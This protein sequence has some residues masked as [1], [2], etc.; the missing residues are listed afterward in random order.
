[1]TPDLRAR[2]RKFLFLHGRH[3]ERYLST[4]F[5]PNTHLTGEAL[6]LVYL[7]EAFPEWKCAPRWRATGTRVL[8]GALGW[9]V[10]ADGVYFE[11]A[12]YYHRYTADIYTHFYLLTRQRQP[13]VAESVRPKLE[14][15]LE[16]LVWINRPDGT[17]P[18]VGDDDG[19]RLVLLDER[20]PADFRAALSTG[21]ALFSR[22]DFF[23]VAGE[24]A[25]ETFWL[26][27]EE[28]IKT[29]QGTPAAPP[30]ELSRGFADGGYYVMRDG[31]APASNW[32]LADCGVHGAMNCGHAHA[33]ALSIQLAARGVTTLVDP[34]TCRYTT[35]R[36]DRDRFRSSLVHNTVSVDGQ[37][38]SVSSGPFS[39]SHVASV[40]A[41]EWVTQPRF[42][43]LEGEHDG[44]QRLADP[45]RHVRSVLFIRGGYWVV[46]DCLEANG[47]IG[48]CRAF[49]SRRG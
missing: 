46:R 14:A 19:G 28:G 31:W 43:F 3:V 7:A 12:T 49:S 24:P 1:M 4:Y 30:N 33:D 36:G 48:T 22:P 45:V 10:R 20:P 15:L 27:G 17:T 34:G 18:N 8:A 9:H 23:F 44:F 32:L 16:H 39:W 38:S 47:G 2:A 35:S 5:S 6:G 21:A 29:L 37:S 40:R 13:A 26:L 42:D 41:R 25:E 11:Q